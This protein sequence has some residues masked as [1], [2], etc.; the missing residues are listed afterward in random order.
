MVIATAGGALQVHSF[1]AGTRRLTLATDRPEGTD[2]AAIDPYGRWIWW[3]D[4]TGGDQFGVWRRQPWGSPARRRPETPIALPA[5]HDAGL[6]LGEDGTAVVGRSNPAYGTQIHQVMVGPASAGTDLPVL[7]YANRH[8]ALAA[9]LSADADLV[10]IEHSERGDNRHPALRVVA[11]DTGRVVGDLD[12]GAGRGLW[13]LAFAPLPGDPRLLVQHERAGRPA[14]LVWDPVDGQEHPLALGLEGDV[15][16]ADWYPDGRSVL[17]TM[18]YNARSRMYRHDLVSGET[19]PVGPQD[20][21]VEDATVRPDGDVWFVWSSAARPRSVRSTRTGGEVVSV[22]A[23]APSSVGVRDVWVDGSGGRIHALLR[24]PPGGTAPYPTVVAVHGGPTWHDADT[25]SAEAAAWVDHGFAVVQVNYRGSTGYGSAWRDAFSRS[26]GFTELADVAA[27]HDALVARGVVDPGR[28]VLAGASW[29]GYLT[30]L[31]LGTQPERW[32]LG[33]AAVPLADWPT[34]YEDQLDS[35]RA[36]DRSLFGG[37][38]AERPE[39]YR[40]ASPLTYVSGVR[41][42]LLV[43]AGENDPQCPVRQVESY[44]AALRAA[45][46][47]CEVY[48]YDAGHGS[49]VDDERVRQM[50]A[51]LTFALRLLPLPPPPPPLP[52][53]NAGLGAD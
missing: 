1:D 38:P 10:A 23:R 39:A 3:F 2:T 44:V 26:V 9:A 45:G 20:G 8:D 21:T 32:A 15:A 40:E 30:L 48:R 36:F 49:L 19:S 5:A 7:L 43:I 18:D 4:D 51:M 6:L 37:S 46:G 22:G 50:R 27:V 41:A 52:L 25:F 16:D 11:A 29:G 31:G 17:V 53:P 35:L 12:D 28:S 33:I 47:T 13:A 42:P 34:A 24:E 14:L